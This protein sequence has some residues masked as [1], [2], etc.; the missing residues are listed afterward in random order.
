MAPAPTPSRGEIW[1]VNF[2]PAVGAEIQKWRPALVVSVDSIG[3][4]PL[5]MVVPITDWKPQ[6]ANYPWFVEIP[7]DAT[8]G[9][10]KP[11]QGLQRERPEQVYLR[12]KRDRCSGL[13]PQREQAL[14]AGFSLC[15]RFSQVNRNCSFIR[16]PTGFIAHV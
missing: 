3:R 8:N 15:L 11:E 9:L 2:D 1:L 6:Y 10:S 12:R 5:R 14:V 4:L 7:A 16:R 13:P